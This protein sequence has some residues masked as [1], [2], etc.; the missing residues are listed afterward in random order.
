MS[1]FLPEPH[2][3]L[4]RLLPG[5]ASICLADIRR[6]LAAAFSAGGIN[7]ADLDA[8]F[9]IAHVL[10]LSVGEIPLRGELRP[11]DGQIA[12]LIAMGHR[13]LKGEPVA[14]LLGEWDFYGRTFRLTPA[15]LVPRPDTET[16]VDIILRHLAD[17]PALVADLG[18]GSG[19]ILATL[20]AER[21]RWRGIATDLS[22]EA[23]TTA[24]ANAAAIGVADRALFVRA[25]YAAA[26]APG[27]FDLIASN[28]PY[29]ATAVLAG[30]SREVRDHDPALALDGGAD[31]LAA[32]RVLAPQALAALRPGGRIALEI[33]FDQA[34]AV[35]AILAAA[36]FAA[37]ET[38]RDLG[39][40][41]RVVAAL[42]PA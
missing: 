41:D 38:S 31:G 13:R 10:D 18:T 42:K 39:G 1:G 8:R 33:G 28:P 21:P 2:A 40:N 23:L 6:A 5:H 12:R 20:L 16:L 29:I 11:T 7:D 27:R 35:T 4:A 14:R 32:Y 22:A 26:L 19:A 25:S 17:A 34:V 9:I 3:L 24:C 37:I 36:G 30:L 15:T